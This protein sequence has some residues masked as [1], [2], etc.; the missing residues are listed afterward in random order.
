MMHTI[1]VDPKYTNKKMTKEDVMN[2][3]KKTKMKKGQMSKNFTDMMKAM[4]S[5]HNAE[6]TKKGL[7]RFEKSNVNKF[8]FSLAFEALVWNEQQEKKYNDKRNVAFFSDTE[9]PSTEVIEEVSG[10]VLRQKGLSR[11]HSTDQA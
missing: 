7:K 10:N 9:T 4:M 2:D 6:Y 1:R 3:L 8:K 5:R 11:L